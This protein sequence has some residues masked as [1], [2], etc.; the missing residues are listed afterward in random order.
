MLTL[1]RKKGERVI[2][3]HGEN[4]IVITYLD[5]EDDRIKLGFEAQ[6]HVSID[7]EEIRLRKLGKRPMVR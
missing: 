4:E 1:Y 6:K 7:R 5:S 3:G 2:V